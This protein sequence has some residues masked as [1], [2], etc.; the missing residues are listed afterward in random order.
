[1]KQRRSALVPIAVFAAVAA[2]V[3]LSHRPDQP[4]PFLVPGSAA[5]PTFTVQV[6][7]PRASLPLGG[8]LPPGWF[9]VDGALEFDSS[10]P[11]ARIEMMSLST[12]ALAADGW[13]LK[14]VRDESGSATSDSQ[15]SFEIVF[16][17]RERRV[18]CGVAS[19]DSAALHWAP[20]DGEP[21]MSGHFDVELT[22]LVFAESG[23]PLGWPDGPLRLRGSFDRLPI[24]P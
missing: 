24:D 8:L 6:I 14:L 2:A 19:A 21:A 3:L 12:V 9:G 15:V 5:A 4:R 23:E 18:T 22:P 13:T 1:M 10:S 11:G 16:E 17:E 7:R 20:L